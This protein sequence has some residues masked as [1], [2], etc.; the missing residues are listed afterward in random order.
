MLTFRTEREK[1]FM[2]NIFILFLGLFL[3]ATAVLAQPAPFQDSLLDQFS[4]K[5][6]LRG[7]IDGK[8]TTHDIEVQWILGHLYM[9]F[10]EVS[11]EKDTTGAPAYEALVTIG[12][13]ESSKQYACLWL[14]NTAAG[15]L[16]GIIAF[17]K[18]EPDRIAFLF[19]MK[20]GSL[21]HT[22]FVRDRKA[23][24]WEWLMDGEENGKREPFARVRLQRK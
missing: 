10:R 13:D 9:Q 4:G 14:D 5:W 3:T 21:F 16:T 19:K 12:W 6:V 15:G 22:I 7:T 8:Q 20:V 18:R 24:S 17:A 1:I 11:R 2:K 23:D